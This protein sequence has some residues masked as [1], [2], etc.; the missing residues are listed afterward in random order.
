MKIL[1]VRPAAVNILQHLQVI[2]S[3]PLELEYLYTVAQKHNWEP[4]IYDG[5]NSNKSLTKTIK[6]FKPDVI[7]IT[8][9]ITHEKLI[10]KYVELA[11]KFDQNIITIVGGVHA[12]LNYKNFYSPNTDFIFRS[13]DMIAFGTLLDSITKKQIDYSNINALCW[14]KNN[15]WIENEFVSVD[16]NTLP[17][18]DRSFFYKN[19]KWFRYID[20]EETATIKT[21]LSCPYNCN[22]CY[23]TQL[24]GKYSVRNLN[25]V[26]QEIE[27][28]QS[29]NIL[30]ADD[31]FLFDEKRIW[32]FIDEI[33]KRNINKNFIC[34]GRADYISSHPEQIKALVEIG[35]I[36]FL[37][38]IESSSDNE[39]NEYNKQIT[40]DVNIQCINLLNELNA[41]CFALMIIPIDADKS[42]FYN[43]YKWII[44]NNVQYVTLSIFTPMPG[45]KNFKD[46]LDKLITKDC[47]SWDFLHLV[48]KPTK[49]STL[50]FYFEFYKLTYKLYKYTQKTGIFNFMNFKY[51]KNIIWNYICQKLRREL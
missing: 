28:I 15:E 5:F 44:K 49:L 20:L 47:T 2:N 50:S 19:K 39:L 42:Y 11:K 48:L 43:L 22:F 12:Q 27:E 8:G 16:I 4:F 9:Y 29:E 36:Y 45:T 33:K 13:E 26:I 10:L 6:E 34:Y 37:V 30:I 17:I 31:L 32:N 3:E 1:L 23:C 35:F 24:A 40:A 46:Y 7:G 38:G 18:P 41:R 14:K 51:Y 25:K 21:S